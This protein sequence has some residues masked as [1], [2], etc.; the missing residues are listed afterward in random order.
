MKER[1][2]IST[3]NSPDYLLAAVREVRDR[4]I[5]VVEV[6]SPFA[7]PELTGLLGMRP[8]RLPWFCLSLGLVGAGL[9]VWFE[10]WTTAVDWPVNVGGKPWNSLLAFVPVTFEVLVLFA[11]VSTILGFLLTR[12]LF[13]GKKT[14]EGIGSSADDQFILVLRPRPNEFDEGD[15]E[16]LLQGHQAVSNWKEWEA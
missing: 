2:L 5:E 3:F 11:A 9:K 10:F 4:G 8:S 16:R 1:V 6:Y 7:L 12:R 15:L 13:P 14:I